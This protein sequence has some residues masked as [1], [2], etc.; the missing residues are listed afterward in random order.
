MN[1]FLFVEKYRPTTIDDVIVP[2]AITSQLNQM[3][4][5]GIQNSIFAGPPGTGKTTSAIALCKDVSCDYIMIN[6]SEEGGIDTIRGRIRQFASTV[7]FSESG[8]K[9][10]ILDEADY[11]STSS[12]PALRGFIEE[13]SNTCR[14]IFTANYVNRII[15]ALQSRCSIYKFD[16]SGKEVST[17]YKKFYDRAVMIL[18]NE[19][20]EFNKKIVADV[21]ANHAP[22][23]RR[24]LNEFQRFSID[25]HLDESIIHSFSSEQITELYKAIKEKNFRDMRKWVV[26]NSMTDSS[27][28]FRSLYDNAHDFIEPSSIPQLVLLIAQYQYQDA[29]AVDKEINTTALLLEMA[30][31]LVFK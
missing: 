29:F 7:S 30:T 5:E 27:H 28:I 23:W 25:G 3:R 10:V 15:P 22:D 31:S 18:D 20:I 14:F 11:L 26:E 1:D 24:I 16:V 12:Q 21:I 9:V 17:L 19:G 2:K 13:F 4:K 8:L 6:A